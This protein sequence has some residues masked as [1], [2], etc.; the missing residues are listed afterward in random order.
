MFLSLVRTVAAGAAGAVLVAGCGGSGASSGGT[1]SAAKA[2]VVI[3][4]IDD[5]TGA[6]ASIGVLDKNASQLAVDRINKSG[7]ANGH[8]LKLV[9]YDN[10]SDP[11][12][13]ATLATRLVTQDG[14]V[15]LSCCASST[16][17]AA[18]AQVAGQLH[19]PMLTSA[20][21]QSLTADSQPWKGY[22]YRVAL[23]NNSLAKY[24][25][26]FIKSKGWKRIALDT[27]SLS[28]GTDSIPFFKSYI[29]QTGG[30]IVTE[31]SLAANISDASVPAAQILQAKPDVVLSWDYP[32]PVAQL[33]KALRAAGSQVPIVSN[34][35][36]INPTMSSIAGNSI[37]DLYAH[38][39]VQPSK[40]AV[41]GYVK[42]YQAA[43]G[44]PPSQTF[45]AS[46]GYAHMQVAAAAVAAAKS[47]D[48]AGV[49]AGL[50]SLK[51]VKTLVGG[52]SACITY[53]SGNYEGA[54]QDPASFLIMKALKNG[55]WVPAS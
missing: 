38:D 16:A 52:D 50:Q 3:G 54:H 41:Q 36:A 25:V 44:Q 2:P 20:V 10:K 28:Y 39:A 14:A 32:V 43:Y 51:C 9:F 26:D 12:L 31:V 11:A 48:A 34:W 5:L 30:T 37:A 7:G 49:S 53:G 22:V 24:N 8:P 55:E 47:P 18:A 23:D 42:D 46:F 1:G 15:L 40:T 13:T 45:Q 4:A 29:A 33:T 27:S 35:S 17:T 21:Q 19:V 6:A